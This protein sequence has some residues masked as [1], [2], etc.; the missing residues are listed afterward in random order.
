MNMFDLKQSG[1]SKS[2]KENSS[3]KMPEVV[4]A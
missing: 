3:F 1:W 2:N 4:S